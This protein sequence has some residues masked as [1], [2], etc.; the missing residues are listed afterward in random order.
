MPQNL[1]NNLTS[2]IFTSSLVLV[3]LLCQ[4]GILD[5]FFAYPSTPH[6][7]SKLTSLCCNAEN[8]ETGVSI[9]SSH[10]DIS[11]LPDNKFTYLIAFLATASPWFSYLF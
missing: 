3:V 10:Q 6:H 9:I 4:I 1:F 5:S 7:A 8:S 2:I 11:N